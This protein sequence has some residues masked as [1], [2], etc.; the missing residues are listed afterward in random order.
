MI[1]EVEYKI[2]NMDFSFLKKLYAKAD[3]RDILEMNILRVN[4]MEKC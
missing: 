3:T 2:L 4:G 1:E